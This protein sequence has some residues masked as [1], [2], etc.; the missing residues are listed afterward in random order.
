MGTGHESKDLSKLR[1][2]PFRRLFAATG[3]MVRVA[4]QEIVGAKLIDDRDVAFVPVFFKIPGHNLFILLLDGHIGQE[5]AVES[6]C[7]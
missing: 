2:H 4:D 3:T 1:Q 7:E 6:K 5:G